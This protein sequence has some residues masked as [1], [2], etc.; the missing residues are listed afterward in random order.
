MASV[1][2]LASYPRIC[3]DRD[4]CIACGACVS[5]CPNNALELDEEGKPIVI[6]ERC[7]GGCTSTL[8]GRLRTV[9]DR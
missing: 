8:S 1:E 9:R 5:V 4:Q 2:E 7:E 6:W 3:R